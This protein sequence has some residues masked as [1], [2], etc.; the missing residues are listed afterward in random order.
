[1]VD[2]RSNAC[3]QTNTAA[4]RI[5]RTRPARPCGMRGTP[6]TAPFS[7]FR[8]CA[9]LQPSSAATSLSVRSSFSAISLVWYALFWD[10]NKRTLFAAKLSL[11]G[12]CTSELRTPASSP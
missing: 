9:G 4:R 12:E 11:T 7:R 1:V 5:S 10:H 6:G 2:A 3:I 8:A